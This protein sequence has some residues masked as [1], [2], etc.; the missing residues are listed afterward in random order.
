[1]PTPAILDLDA[2]LAPIPGD[3]PS[4]ASVAFSLREKLDQARKEVF[5]ED[6][7]ANDP[8]RPSEPKRAD[9]TGI[10]SQ[11]SE[12]LTHNSKDLLLV[13]RLIEAM[14]ALHGF[15][16]LR[17]GF[18]LAR[19]LI[20]EAWDRLRPP[21]EEPDDLEV[22][23]AP[24]NWL[25]D[26]DRGAFFPNRVRGVRLLDGPAGPISWAD[27]N[28]ARAGKGKYPAEEIEKAVEAAPREACQLVVDDIGEIIGEVQLLLGLMNEK[29]GREAPGMTQFRQAISDCQTLAVQILER[30]GPPPR[31][32]DRSRGGRRGRRG[33]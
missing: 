29:M 8:M 21:I 5:P 13:A 27:W 6:F 17:D 7:K 33:R 1:M 16:G 20:E 31:R 9:W 3:D 14:T 22:R 23:A 26:T 11:T 32:R 24:L 25:D 19:R 4:G 18:R 2:L 30:K 15:A 10:A 28:L 12:A